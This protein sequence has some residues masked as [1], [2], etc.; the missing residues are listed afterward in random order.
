MEGQK[1]QLGASATVISS[2]SVTMGTSV[3]D[4]VSSNPAN[5]RR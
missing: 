5:T 2:R 1:K 4:Q 3:T